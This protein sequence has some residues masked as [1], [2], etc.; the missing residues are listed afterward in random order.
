MNKLFL[1]GN[2]FDLAHGLKTRYSDFL[3]W[4]INRMINMLNDSNNKTY[5][6][7]LISIESNGYSI[8]EINSLEALKDIRKRQEIIIKAKNKFF[9]R[10]LNN[11]LNSNWVDIE[12]EYYLALLDLYIKYETHKTIDKKNATGLNHCL[13]L[14]KAQLSE[15]LLT[16]PT[17]I[18]E[19]D[20]IKVCFLNEMK[21][22]PTENALFLVFNYTSTIEKYLDSIDIKKR[23]VIYIHGKLRDKENPI[24]FGYGDE[25]NEYYSRLEDLNENE[26]LKNMKSFSYFKTENYSLLRSF[27][28]SNI[29][30]VNIIGHSCGISDRL[31]LNSIFCN[32]NCDG[33]RIYYYQKNQNENDYFE[34]TLE[35]SRHFKSE[36]KARMRDLIVPFSR[37][38]PLS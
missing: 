32:K 21:D 34:K 5:E 8:R 6:D 10:I 14:L 15:Y 33:I 27:M 20:A 37:S 11:Y 19:N 7:D 16:I 17:F 13:D 1:I 9:E 22:I 26:F 18:K 38:N 12:Y 30:K 3:L 31:L 2:G 24:I 4:F 36:D 35:I 25:M 28:E 23:Q 29:Y